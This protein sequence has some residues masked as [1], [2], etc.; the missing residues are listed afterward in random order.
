MTREDNV[1]IFEDTVDFCRE[2][3][4]LSECI[5]YGRENQSLFL[6]SDSVPSGKGIE[7][8][9]E[10]KIIV[11]KKRSF[12]AASFYAR[13]GS[14]VCVLNFASASNP[15]GGV[16][17]GSRAQEESLCRIS[18]LYFCLD[19]DEMWEKFYSPHRENPNPLHN[20]DAI[21]TPNVTVF[22]DDTNYP[23]LMDE[24]DWF[25]VDVITC[26]APNL[27]AH[28]S[29]RYNSGDGDLQKKISDE[30]LKKIHEKRGR[31]I[32]DIAAMKGA[33]VV[34]LGAFGCGAFENNPKVVAD[35]LVPLAKEY[36]RT[37]RQIEFAVFCPPHDDT[38]YLAFK[39][40]LERVE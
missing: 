35:A 25:S 30:D 34:I 6:E 19:T 39:D 8:F 11:S 12:E 9:S 31:R 26:A 1:R 2:T 10:T 27:R 14:K 5:K 17:N 4:R 23:R 13:N 22:K 7:R 3:P 18:T 33:E 40:S 24:K 15:G 38:N 37:F 16:V 21:F 20:D 32:L 28:P 36:S 29:N